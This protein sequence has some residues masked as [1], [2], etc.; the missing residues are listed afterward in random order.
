VASG[1][2]I[3]PDTTPA[4]ARPGPFWYAYQ[5]AI[6][7]WWQR[8]REHLTPRSVYFQ[9]A[10]RLAVA[11]AAARLLAGALDL[12]HGFWVLLATLTLL[13]TSAADTRSTLRPALVGTLAGAVLAGGL[14]VAGPSPDVYVAALPLVMLIGFAAGPLFG[15]GWAQ[16]LFTV[17]IALVFAQ[18]APV[19]WRLAEARLLD[20]AVGAAVG[21]LIGVFAWPRGGAGELHRAVANFLTAS[22]EV[23]HEA[24]A[25]LATAAPPGTALPHARQRGRFAEASYA[26]YQTERHQPARLD[27]QATLGTGYHAVHGAEAL[28]RSCPSGRLLP[29]VVPLS[30]TA[31]AV[32][33]GYGRL[34]AGVLQR[35]PVTPDGY[36]AAT[37]PEQWPTDLGADLYHLADIR[38]WLTGLGD[39]LVRIAAAPSPELDESHRAGSEL[40]PSSY[41]AVRRPA[42][43]GEDS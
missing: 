18:M 39:D 38:V 13:R 30:A 2:P 3:R 34:A 17:V 43:G 32:A 10:L 7:L 37:V 19:T 29:C 1:A 24:V 21:V 6:S 26:L 14:L 11:L 35:R 23:V 16:A 25:V 40:A 41:R 27:W 8:F 5:P 36:A 22:A 28:L 31:T 33:D 15:L 12:S 42:E 20:V 4:S 9:G